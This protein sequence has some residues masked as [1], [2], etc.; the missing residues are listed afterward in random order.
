MIMKQMNWIGLFSGM[1]LSTSAMAVS[2]WSVNDFLAPGITAPMASASAFAD[3]ATGSKLATATVCDYSPVGYGV[4]NSSEGTCANAGVGPHAA[5]NSLNTD[6]FLLGFSSAVTLSSVQIGWNGTDNWRDFSTT[7]KDSDISVLAYTGNGVPTVAGLT[8][9]QLVGSGWSVIGN[10]GNVGSLTSNTAQITTTTSSSWWLISAY[11]S[12]FG[13]N[14]A[15]G[16]SLNNGD[17]YFKLLSVAGMTTPT[18]T[19]SN[20]PEPGSLALMGLAL[21]GILSTKLRKVS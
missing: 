16:K 2:N 10:Y 5:D 13:T 6:M 9:S 15:N 14:S 8:I 19:T 1:I 18:T 4:V 12:G 17:D 20:V 7:A 3:T 11:N 21:V